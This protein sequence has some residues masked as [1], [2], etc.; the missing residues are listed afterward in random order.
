MTKTLTNL[1]RP[2]FFL[3][4][5]IA[6][7]PL[8]IWGVALDS[9]WPPAPLATAN[10]EC[11][12][13]FTLVFGVPY[14]DNN[15]G[16]TQ[17]LP[18]NSCNGFASPTANDVWFTFTYTANMDSLV[19]A[20]PLNPLNDIVLELFSGACGTLNF[21]SCANEAAQND[22]NQSE[23]MYLGGLGLIVGNTYK[24][25]VYGF[26]GVQTSFTA[27]LKSGTPPAPP[28]N[29]ECNSA[30][31][32]FAGSTIGGTTLGATQ[33]LAPITCN[34]NTSPTARDV[35]YKFTKSGLMDSLA[36]FPDNN[37]DYVVEIRSNPCST[38]NSILCTDR[39]GGG[40]PEKL[41][42]SSL[43]N[44]TQYLV[45][46]YGKNVG[47][48][49]FSVR[50]KIA[51]ANNNCAGA[52]ELL[53]TT[54]QP[55]ST[56][57]AS[58]T[59][60]LNGCLGTADDDVW[61]KFSMTAGWDS[62]AVTPNGFFNPVV[63]LRAGTCPGTSSLGCSNGSQTNATEKI[64]IGNLSPGTT[65]LVRVHSFLAGE[66]A[67]GSFTIRIIQGVIPG[68][69]NDNCTSPIDI[70]PGSV[71]NGNN[72][73]ATQTSPG[74]P[75]GGSVSTSALDVWYRFTKTEAIDT[76]VVDGLGLFDAMMDVR[77]NSCPNGTLSACIDEA[78]QEVKK[79]PVGFLTNGTTYLLRV[80]GRNGATGDFTL[81]FLDA[82]VIVN[83][84]PNDECFAA[85]PLSL[86]TNCQNIAGTNA[87]GTETLPAES[88]CSGSDPGTVKDVWYSFTANGPRAIIR[89]TCNVGFNGAIQVFS[90]SCFGLN[91]IG[92]TDQ[93]LASND[94]DFP[95]VEELFLNNLTNG[96]TYFVR[97]YGPQGSEGSFGICAFNPACNSTAPT[98]TTSA[99][100]LLSN[101][102][103]A[104]SIGGATGSASYERS[105]NQILWVPVPSFSSSADTLVFR[106]AQTE[107]VYLRAVNRT[108]D[109]YPAYS[110][111]SSF[112]LRCATPF[113]NET[114]E[115]RINRVQFGNI[116]NTSTSNPLGG[117]VQD[118]SVITGNFCRGNAYNLS[119]TV[120]NPG[121]SYNRLAWID[122]N[123]DGDFADA[124]ESVWFGN[125][126][127]GATT[128]QSI[129]IPGNA[130]L[131]SCRMRVAIIHNGA[132][133]P[134]GDACATGPYQFGEIE[135]Y[136]LTITS[137]VLANAG[138]N[139]S[140]CVGSQ[141]LSGNDP[142]AGSSGLWTVVSG[143]GSF[144]NATLF[145]TLVS[146]LG[147]GANVFRW[148]LTNACGSSQSE[149]TI[150]ST[151]VQS[152]AGPD[153]SVCATTASLAAQTPALGTGTWTVFSGGATVTNPGLV[154]SGVTNLG[155]GPN[156]FIWTVS[157]P[158]P[159]CPS[160]KDT[161]T[162]NRRT[163]PIANAGNNQSLCGPGATLG[164]LSPGS[165]TGV[166]TLVSGTGTISNPGQNN[167]SVTGLGYGPNVFRWTVTDAPCAAVS[168]E[169]TLSNNLP[170]KPELGQD[171]K[172]CGISNA[173][174]IGG[175]VPAGLTSNW[176]L[177]SG[178]GI[179]QNPGNS[180]TTV[181]GLAI[182][183][184]R[185]AWVIQVPAC[186]TTVSDTIS[187]F[188]EAN[189]VNL[190]PDTL[191]CSNFT[192]VY[193]V[194]GPSGMNSYL[195]S[196]GATTPQIN[197]SSPDT[198]ILTVN[199]P[200][201]CSFADTVKITF[202]ICDGIAVL[203]A[204]KGP[205]MVL[206]PNPGTKSQI[207]FE[208]LVPEPVFMEIRD[209]QG[210]SIVTISP[211]RPDSK[212]NI[213][214]PEGLPP[215]MYPIRIF[216]S[217]WNRTLKWIIQ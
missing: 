55:G 51:R 31:T 35:W 139:Q 110:A 201:G 28:S 120:Q 133:I 141:T 81:E 140:T 101:Q 59:T 151:A 127:A 152:N 66:G 90:G 104:A 9:G 111:V 198:V 186:S 157:N 11:A 209:A 138:P 95:T 61:F 175:Q 132:P 58:G 105:V 166:W 85:E 163:S 216:G 67:E 173:T 170:A 150:T 161:V 93:F 176:V 177:V 41:S 25:R 193:T 76:I 82:V 119:L 13:A 182:G 117:N 211:V 126:T 181:S 40:L 189:P 37:T 156:R 48:G 199:T 22:D 46:I 169:V 162:I 5:L 92:C 98:L 155:V 131:G 188:R 72:V 63:E 7:L 203:D 43:T 124:G 185:F 184:N 159:G 213:S 106:S 64:Y 113:L 44:G 75:C 56:V 3:A 109:C 172:A 134:N 196:S 68:P 165:G 212:G 118:F 191:V 143:S 202:T 29:D 215:G 17:S 86:G 147:P 62:I 83:P 153:Q 148:T 18:P 88:S 183:N 107:T 30:I 137:G 47:A 10:N 94:P 207:H 145:N 65:Y 53:N 167:S 70:S 190:G 57:D 136:S 87:G 52:T 16:A 97:V 204:R 154:N 8:K 142:G 174:L 12:G 164:A 146:N 91:S 14:S 69:A 108:G 195:W 79:M 20:P 1:L 208:T 197:V 80:Y 129:S 130:P 103:F 21:V 114:T 42:L 214:L 78:G 100:S 135:E 122:F 180:T 200:A 121:R 23:G 39:I 49:D 112:T 158:T 60:G 32:L 4:V 210:K 205:E 34:G 77:T 206:L 36:L 125:Y 168:D 171:L 178:T 71:I 149:V 144:A 33:S 160:V 26:N 73:N 27:L 187:V 102:A 15:T 99:T 24:L 74:V 2:C 84:P 45:R 19:V 115:D 192:P 96:Q 179:L 38:G 123:Q 50:I 128:S 6:L 217:G 116:D 89:V 54:P 194:T